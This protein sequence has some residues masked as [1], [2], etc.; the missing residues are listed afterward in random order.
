M[1][2]LVR[3]GRLAW[4]LYVADLA[5][6]KRNTGLGFFSPLVSVILYSLI[7]GSV[8][9]LVFAEP[10]RWFIPFF[11]VSYPLWQA[12]STSVVEAAHANEKASG[13]LSFP[14]ISASIVYLVSALNF[15]VTTVLR[16]IAA[17][18]VILV[19]D[20]HILVTASYGKMSF[21]LVLV[22]A[23]LLSWGI[24]LSYLFDRLRI[25]RGYLPQI[26]MAAYL[27]TPILWPPS[28][29]ANHPWIY[30][31]NP[32]YHLI[33]VIRAP[34]LS[35]TIPLGSAAICLG[36][37]LIGTLTSMLAFSANRRL[38]VHGWVA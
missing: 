19:I 12:I 37:I 27:L 5:Q 7:L 33:E 36:L 4:P 35:G 1:R 31:L 14:G 17:A 25:L 2:S 32:L 18:L 8:M 26:L 6:T 20:P 9:A 13:F 38:I 23:V 34:A 10:I 24:T 21:G 11:A 28:R 3:Q 30:Q 22:S 29:L 16:L 15:L